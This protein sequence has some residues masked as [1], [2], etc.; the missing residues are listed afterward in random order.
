MLLCAPD[1][2]LS[3]G[4]YLSLL[5]R[6]NR[7]LWGLKA[8]ANPSGVVRLPLQATE[9]NMYKAIFRIAPGCKALVVPNRN[10]MR[11]GMK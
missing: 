11:G 8:H 2:T 7:A 3:E 5:G 1:G 9:S 4:R 10:C 6:K